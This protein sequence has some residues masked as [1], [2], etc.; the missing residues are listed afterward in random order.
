MRAR[1]RD[2]SIVMVFLL[3]ALP[4]RAQAAAIT[5][6]HLHSSTVALSVV[7]ANG[8]AVRGTTEMRV[9][10][11]ND[12]EIGLRRDPLVLTDGTSVTTNFDAWVSGVPIPFLL[13]YDGR[14]RITMTL[15]LATVVNGPSFSVTDDINEIFIPIR[16]VNANSSIAV[17]N[18][19]LNGQPITGVSSAVNT[20]TDAQDVLRI[21]GASLSKGFLL[22]GTV[23]MRWT[24][25]RPKGSQLDA[26]VWLAKVANVPSDTQAPTVTFTAPA[27]GSLLAAVEPT[28]AATYSDSG[29]GIDPASVRL[30]LDGTDRTAEAQ[31]TG[32]GLSLTPSAPLA[33][34]GHTAQVTVR[35]LA[36][37]Q[38]QASVSFTTDTV[39]PAIAFTSPATEGGFVNA[40]SLLVAGTVSDASPVVSVQING[41]P[42]PLVNGT[43]QSTVTLVDGINEILIDAQDAAGNQGIASRFVTL[44][45]TP[46]ELQVK[47]PSAGQIVNASQIQVTGQATDDR[48]LA[49]V[50]VQGNAVPVSADLFAATVPVASGDNLISVRAV[51]RAGN[52]TIVNVPVNR[53]DLPDVTITSPADLSFLKTTTVDVSG[54]VSDPQARVTVNGVSATASGTTFTAPGVP[55]IEG[56]NILTATATDAHG[57]VATGTINVVRDL[58]PPHLAVQY[59]LDGSS[60]LDSSVTVT[61][62]VNDIVAGTVNAAQAT[63]TVNGRP[64]TVANRSFVAAGVPLTPGDNVLSI[65]ATDASGNTGEARTTVRFEAPSGPRISIL[66]GNLQENAIGTALPQPLVVTLLGAAGQPAPGRTVLFKVRGNDGSLDGGKRQIALVTDASGQ[67]AAHFTLGLRAGAANQAVEA[68]AAGFQGPAVFLATARPGPAAYI[69]VDSGDQQVG[70][71]GR[72]LPRPLVAVVTDRGYNRLEGIAV[73]F[74]V[75]QGRG[76]FEN[77]LQEALTFSDSDGRLILP[78]ALDPEEGIANNVVEARI[79]GLDTSPVASFAASGRAAGDPA[80]TSISGVVLDTA[81]QPLAGVTL[82][83]L[84]TALTA[85]TDANGLFKI[86]S[87][88]IGTVKL[89]VDGSTAERPGTWPDLEYVLTTIPG[90]DN[91]V[92]MPIYLLPL[93]QHNGVPVDETHGGTLTLPDVPGF[94]LEIAPGSVT[95]PGGSRSG[96]VSVTVVHNDRVPM[97]PNFGQQPRLIVTIQPAG[98]RFDPPARLTLPNLEGLTPGAVAEMYSFDHDLGHFVSIGPA[99]VSEDGS[100]VTSN[101]GVG[102]I[103]AGWHC[104]GN[105]AGTGTPNHCDDCLKCD[106]AKCVPDTGALCRSCQPGVARACDGEGH[107]LAGKELIPKICGGITIQEDPP[108]RGE[109]EQV[110][111]LE[112]LT[113]LCGKA[114][115]VTYRRVNHTCDGVDLVG[116]K[117]SEK[118]TTDFGCNLPGEAKIGP[119]PGSC[120]VQ[121]D[122]TLAPEGFRCRDYYWVCKSI[123]ALPDQFS[124]RETMTQKIFIDNCLV[125]TKTMVFTITKSGD[126]CSG[127]AQRQ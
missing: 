5:T 114:I 45:T 109:C 60:V 53:F 58:T 38:G 99:T 14:N 11:R 44:D 126:Q 15:A 76:H 49:E 102:V 96:V 30:L 86:P 84:D 88:P 118:I 120:D 70:I 82:R 72:L 127:T 17:G 12:W 61:G 7:N 100:T 71:A 73:K 26:Q 110:P 66:S 36:G 63:V 29:S 56:G 116:G 51:D 113:G 125:A 28:I 81:S 75:T 94:A 3:I 52:E 62:L 98:A 54:T 55:L 104:C 79:D 48:E 33:D 78:F 90:R 13:A 50:M 23:T 121:L 123:N 43:F 22:A 122:N 67:A 40:A 19:L 68:S 8:G 32:S 2:L 95:F 117:L 91:T 89:I 25:T 97:V 119:V 1:V 74:S 9:G 85:R 27:A 115:A 108:G 101:L 6:S 65:V 93:D 35:D 112:G 20:G 34:G 16:A 37:N 57:H 4:Y 31:V 77:S 41:I 39:P 46:P 59:P 103:K 18:L 64:A 10:G 69:V 42:A 24:G 105:P 21:Q 106:G 83:V 111:N 47:T 87:A 124:C 107:C 80:A 92:N